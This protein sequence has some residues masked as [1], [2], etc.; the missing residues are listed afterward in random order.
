[1]TAWTTLIDPQRA[2]GFTHY[3]GHYLLLPFF[4]DW[5]KLII[6][7]LFEG[8]IFGSAAVLFYERFVQVDEEDRF[9]FRTVARLWIHLVLALVIMNGVILA[10][11]VG[12][13]KVLHPLLEYSPRRQSAFR[14]VGLPAAY[15]CV[16]GLFFY[17]V[18]AIAVYG[19]NIIDGLRRTVRVFLRNPV[20]SVVMAG[21]V[22]AGPILLS[23]I[24]SSPDTLVDR[25]RPELVYYLLVAG[26]FA[27]AVAGFFWMGLSVRMLVDQ[28]E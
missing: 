16:A 28:E 25:F 19:E 3:R 12:L 17:L 9:R 20:T 14:W 8:V 13:A 23:N 10:V 5:A 26:L 4:F 6:S 22:L 18:P 2:T 1:V 21:L 7:I 27:E 24:V 11:N 15:V